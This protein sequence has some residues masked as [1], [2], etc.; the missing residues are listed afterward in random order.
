MNLYFRLFYLWL[1]R[2]FRSS[3]GYFDVCRTGFRVW[4]TD[5]DVFLHMNNGRYFVLMDLG[6]T[7]LMIRSKML[8]EFK[9]RG[10][11]PVVV[12]ANMQFYRSLEPFQ[13]FFIETRLIG[14][15]DKAVI[16]E[17]RFVRGSEVV[18][19]GLVR[20]RFLSKQG[21]AVSPAEVAHAFGQP[22]ASPQMP[23]YAQAWNE[24]QS[25]KPKI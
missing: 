20:G 9:R 23:L 18:A 16:M 17:Q 2:K 21:G 5:L 13:K 22:G 10:W 15:D 7:D 14:W 19:L 1:S 12:A 8:P 24:Q 6:R 3:L 4:P 11:Y 25:V